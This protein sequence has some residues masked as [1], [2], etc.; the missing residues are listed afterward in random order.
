[1]FVP[2][3]HDV[4]LIAGQHASQTEPGMFYLGALGE[5]GF[6]CHNAEFIVTN[7]SDRCSQGT[8]QNVDRTRVAAACR[9]QAGWCRHLGSP[10]YHHLLERIADDVDTGG[11]CWTALEPHGA[12]P[13]LTV[14]PLRFLG[15]IHRS[16]LEGRAP[17]LA[18]HYPSAG[19]SAGSSHLWEAFL[20]TLRQRQDALRAY[21]PRVQTNEVGR[22]R[23]LLPGFVAIRKAAS[24]PLRLLEIGA[25]GGLNL[26]W[27]RYRYETAS[28]VWGDPESPVHFEAPFDLGPLPETPRIA[29]RKG[30]DLDPVDISNE[31]GQLTLLSFIWPDQTARLE[32]VRRAIQVSSR[33][34]ASLE[35]ADAVEWIGREL[36][37]PVPGMVTVVFHS[38]VMMYLKEE[39]RRR[40]AETLAEAGARAMADAPLAWLSMEKADKQGGADTAIHLTL[41]PGGQRRHVAGAGFHGQNVRVG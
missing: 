39:Q 1:M 10:L 14:L 26:R 2:L 37:R 36:A 21:L 31:S 38:I 17:E 20:E 3:D 24:L 30:C 18:R 5:C 19:D 6:S 15:A 40:F 27:D 13:N 33:V 9:T 11:L 28:D 35:K 8:I 4:F 25:S 16:V 34:P 32:L 41:W 23:A 12:D 22:C 29:I 7:P